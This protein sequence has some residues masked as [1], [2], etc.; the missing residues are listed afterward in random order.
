MPIICSSL[1]AFETALMRGELRNAADRLQGSDIS[2]DLRSLGNGSL[3]VS[4]LSG[5]L[6]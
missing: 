6:D 2:V 5:T 3:S 1:D 4:L